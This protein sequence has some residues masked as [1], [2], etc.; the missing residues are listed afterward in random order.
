MQE[1]RFKIT[2]PGQEVFEKL[3]AK[4]FDRPLE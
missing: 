1:G 4:K 2:I 3:N